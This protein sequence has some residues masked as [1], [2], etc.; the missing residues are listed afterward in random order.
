VTAPTNQ[1]QNDLGGVLAHGF[2][3]ALGGVS[4]VLIVAGIV[5]SVFTGLTPLGTGTWIR[6]VVLGVALLVL[7]ILLQGIAWLG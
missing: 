2:A 4:L 5:L 1:F 3:T 7:A 6:V